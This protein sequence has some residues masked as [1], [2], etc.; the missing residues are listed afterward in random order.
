MNQNENK[1][2]FVST[3]NGAIWRIKVGIWAPGF[4]SSRVYHKSKRWEIKLILN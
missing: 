3:A 2:G 1:D 4:E